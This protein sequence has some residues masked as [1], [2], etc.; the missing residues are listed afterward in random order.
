MM[1][2]ILVLNADYLPL[3]ITTLRKGF[4]LTYK[5]KAEIVES[6]YDALIRSAYT[7]APMPSVIRL[8]SYVNLPYRKITLT[9][10]NIFKRDGNKC[11]YCPSTKDLT[12]DHVYPKS[13]GGKDTWE[14]L[15]TCCSSCN[16]K[17]A[18][19][20]PEEAGMTFHGMPKAP[21]AFFMIAKSKEVSENWK[22]YIFM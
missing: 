2:N 10:H 15:V 14:N 16:I 18:N 5:G 7:S 9:R 20:T 22:P 3:S 17:K 21:N 4:K 11:V 19:K 8:L 6:N 13:R 12:L 1:N